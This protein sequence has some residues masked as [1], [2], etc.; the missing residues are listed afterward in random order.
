MPADAAPVIHTAAAAAAATP[1]I[2]AAGPLYYNMDQTPPAPMPEEPPEALPGPTT[3]IDDNP[4]LKG[5]AGDRFRGRRRQHAEDGSGERAEGQQGSP[6][7]P[8]KPRVPPPA[9][10]RK[11]L[12]DKTQTLLRKKGPCQTGE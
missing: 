10:T 3:S 6:V 12:R 1:G 7:S 5:T 4:V 11:P 8:P 2:E 9:P